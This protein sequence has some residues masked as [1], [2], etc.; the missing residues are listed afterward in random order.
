VQLKFDQLDV[1]L[2][3]LTNLIAKLDQSERATSDQ[4]ISTLKTH[5]NAM[6]SLSTENEKFSTITDHLTALDVKL[7]EVTTKS[8]SSIPQ[9]PDWRRLTIIDKVLQTIRPANSPYVPEDE[10]AGINEVATKLGGKANGCTESVYGELHTSSVR[11]ILNAVGLS[12]EDVL[13]DLG[14][15]RGHVVALAFYD[16]MVRRAYGI[17]MSTKRVKIACEFA[18]KLRSRFPPALKSEIA[19]RSI[20]FAEGNFLEMVLTA[21]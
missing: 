17:E 3:K 1:K 9:L 14:A 12:K 20:Q 4:V 19:T 5:S 2:Y 13:Y 11:H 15:G 8:S 6:A 10:K 7:T 16:F 18:S 21:E